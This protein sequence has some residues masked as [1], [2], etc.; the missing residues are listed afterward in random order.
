VL[1]QRRNLGCENVLRICSAYA[2]AA[3]YENQC[4]PSLGAAGPRSKES[5]SRTE[6]DS[7]SLD[8]A[9]SP[10]VFSEGQKHHWTILP[11]DGRLEP[12]QGAART[13]RRPMRPQFPDYL[14][15]FFAA[16]LASISF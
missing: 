15:A 2:C 1:R 14:P 9:V 10:R 12:R 11:P 16:I 13:R 7:G 4:L 6:G 3:G 8:T 5:L